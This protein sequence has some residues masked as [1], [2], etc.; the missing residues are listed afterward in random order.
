M[1]IR[2]F[3]LIEVIAVLGMVLAL[4]VSGLWLGQ[5]WQRQVAEDHYLTALN[6][7][8]QA[9][10]VGAEKKGGSLRFSAHKT[11]FKVTNQAIVMIELPAHIR[12]V[13]ATITVSPGKF[14]DPQVVTLTRAD[15]SKIRLAFQ[16]G[17]GE[18]II[19]R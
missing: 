10:L 19:Q 6:A 1:K 14:A 8:W 2:A 7:H 18:L 5:R 16:M 9:T 3:T 4:S 12:S 11:I 17:W 13:Q 15:G